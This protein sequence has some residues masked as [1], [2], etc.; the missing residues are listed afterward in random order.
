[1]WSRGWVTGAEPRC[2]ARTACGQKLHLRAP[3]FGTNSPCQLVWLQP[4]LSPSPQAYW[5]WILS[6]LRAEGSVYMVPGGCL[7][8]IIFIPRSGP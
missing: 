1:M 8:T 5:R 7:T 6:L 4:D 2:R 3:L